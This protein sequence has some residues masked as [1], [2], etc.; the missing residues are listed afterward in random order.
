M[1]EGKRHAYILVLIEKKAVVK[2]AG[3]ISVRGN[4][5]I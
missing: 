5:I 2:I 1:R 4:K 3:S